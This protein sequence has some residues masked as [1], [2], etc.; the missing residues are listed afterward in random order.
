MREIQIKDFVNFDDA[1]YWVDDQIYNC[2]DQTDIKI[3]I[4]YVNGKW[5]ASYITDTS[6][7]DLFAEE[8]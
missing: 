2:A 4:V 1:L 7:F 3:E 8:K 6:Q 5:R